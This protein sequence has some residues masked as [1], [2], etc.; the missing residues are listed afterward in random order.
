M[1]ERHDYDEKFF[2]IQEAIS[3]GKSR[4]EIARELGYKTWKSLDIY[5][6]RK[7]MKWDPKRSIYY[8]PLEDMA[9]TLGDIANIPH[10]ISLVISLFSKENPDPLEI[11]KRA[12][13]KDHH[14]MGAYMAARGYTWSYEQNNYVKSDKTTKP[15]TEGKNISDSIED[16]ADISQSS[17]SKYIPILETLLENKDKLYQLIQPSLN[18]IPRYVVPGINRTKSF[19][20]SDRLS[21]LV[22]EFSRKYNIS[23]K[24]II[25]AALIEF[26]KKYSFKNE[27]EELL[28]IG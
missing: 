25:E 22:S 13:F 26:L 5:M 15:Y 27:V 2:I 21:N 3:N 4:E 16:N 11:A 8:D 14:E 20:M 24:E 19:Y 23:Q 6:R 12:G 18:S 7:G 10:K 17:L 9:N 28:N 1:T